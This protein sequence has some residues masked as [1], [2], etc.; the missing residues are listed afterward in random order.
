MLY[1]SIFD[2][3]NPSDAREMV[4]RNGQNHKT[5]F[6]VSQISLPPD[7]TSAIPVLNRDPAPDVTVLRTTTRGS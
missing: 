6:R 5:G 7:I 3:D 2:A 1:H 4:S